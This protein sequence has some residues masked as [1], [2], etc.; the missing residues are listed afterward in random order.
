MF[1]QPDWEQPAPPGARP[2]SFNPWRWAVVG[3]FG[4]ILLVVAFFVPIPI[5]YAY[6]PGPTPAVDDLVKVDDTRT[7]SSEG[8]FLVTTVS[9]DIEVTFAEMIWAGFDKSK[10]IVDAESVTGGQSLEQ[11]QRDQEA[12]MRDAN[13]SAEEVAFG[14]LGFGRPKGDG[15]RVLGTVRDYPAAEVLDPGDKIVAVDAHRVQTTC[16]VGRRIDQH[17]IGDEVALTIVRKR[18]RRVVRVRTVAS[19]QDRGAPFLGVYME[20]INY[21]FTPGVDVKFD[22]GDIAGPSAGLMFALSLYDQLTPDDLTHGQTIA[23]TGTIS[24]DGGVGPIGG[25]EQKVA[26]A[27]REGAEIFLSPAANFAAAKGAATDIE[28]VEISN[29]SEAL[30]YLEALD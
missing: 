26:G 9:V 24:C 22:P 13:R 15:A 10:V 3:I 11:L 19:P 17:E 23:G 16:D 8:T 12:Q 28:V 30:D 18:E 20:P 7:Y 1:E 4:A 29:F 2:V 6:L 21:R 14:A 5:F 25:V 27:E